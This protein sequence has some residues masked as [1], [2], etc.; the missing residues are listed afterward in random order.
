MRY[1]TAGELITEDSSFYKEYGTYFEA[2]YSCSDCSYVFS[3]ISETKPKGRCPGCPKCKESAAEKGV[4]VTKGRLKTKKALKENSEDMIASK[5][6]ASIAGKSNLYKAHDATMK[7]VMED[8]GL[9]DIN[10]KPYEGE[11]CVPKLPSHLEK[12]V[13]D[14]FG[15]S[16]GNA[17]KLAGNL[18]PGMIT[19]TGMKQIN[20]GMFRDQGDVVAMQQKYGP[21][22]K[23]NFIN[24]KS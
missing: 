24:E 4:N 2:H 22:P 7:M 13:N 8:Y 17:S 10:D 12:Q 23:Y 11:N 3:I 19:S 20:S 15:A 16:F 5:K 6:T 21:K 14:G 9:T 18:N 1:N